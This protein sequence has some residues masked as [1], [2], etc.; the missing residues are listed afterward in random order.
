MAQKK[1]TPLREVS[2]DFIR[3]HPHPYIRTFIDLANSPN[4]RPI[5]ALPTLTEYS[6]D[7]N[8]YV[9]L[10]M[11]GKI[12]TDEARQTMQERQQKAL[13]KKTARWNR[14]KAKLLAGWRSCL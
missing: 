6:N 12:T 10:L 2:P 7:L 13:D 14:A 4:A 11:L 8:N 5:L 3:N 9:N 1:F